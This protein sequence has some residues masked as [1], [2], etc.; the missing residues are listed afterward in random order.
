[1][2]KK[3]FFVYLKNAFAQPQRY[4]SIY[5]I[6]I[7]KEFKVDLT[8]SLNLFKNK[9]SKPAILFIPNVQKC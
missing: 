1:M 6:E 9:G 8:F 4:R 2:T 3:S 7:R 5:S